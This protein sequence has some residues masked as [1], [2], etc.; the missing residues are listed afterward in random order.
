MGGSARSADEEKIP[1]QYGRSEN[2][3]LF[4][5]SYVKKKGDCQPTAFFKWR[6]ESVDHSI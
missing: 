1:C 5:P 3:T 2:L 6:A 4:F